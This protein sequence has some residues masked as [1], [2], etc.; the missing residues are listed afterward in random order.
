MMNNQLCCVTLCSIMF[1]L[2]YSIALSLADFR[3]SHFST[4]MSARN[5]GKHNMSICYNYPKVHRKFVKHFSLRNPCRKLSV[6]CG[7]METMGY[8]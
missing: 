2:L 6:I 8:R 1:N 5:I 7:T 3:P 4:I